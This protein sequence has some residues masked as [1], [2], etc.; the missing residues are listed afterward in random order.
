MIWTRRA[1]DYKLDDVFSQYCGAQIGYADEAR[2]GKD[3][4][5]R[6]QRLLGTGLA[7]AAALYAVLPGK[8]RECGMEKLYYEIELPLCA[9]LARMETRGVLVDQMALV[10]FGNML[11]VGIQKDQADIFRY[12]AGIQHQLSQ[13]A[14]RDS[15]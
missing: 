13:A 4:R 5:R 14:G 8:L 2:V 9:V 6:R 15:L 7:A 1:G 12:A 3:R 10:A 11:E